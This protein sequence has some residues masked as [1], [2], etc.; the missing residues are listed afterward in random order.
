[1]HS[2]CT[3]TRPCQE[4]LSASPIA[5]AAANLNMVLT[6]LNGLAGLTGV[7]SR[8]GCDASPES[9]GKCFGRGNLE[10]SQWLTYARFEPGENELNMKRDAARISGM[11]D[12]DARE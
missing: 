6:L 3:L 5:S 1:M 11:N 12:E 10:L 4:G 7:L 8:R 2:F 9:Y